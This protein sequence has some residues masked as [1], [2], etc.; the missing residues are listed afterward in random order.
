[1]STNTIGDVLG[2][3]PR[4]IGTVRSTTLRLNEPFIDTVRRFAGRPGT[5]ALVS[6]GTSDCAR[7]HILGIDPWLTLQGTAKTVSIASGGST[8]SLEEEPLAMFDRLVRHYGLAPLE[9]APPIA[10]GLLGYLSYDL[11]DCLETLPRTSVDD[12][13]LP[14]I[15]MVAP[16]I[17]LVSDRVEQKTTVYLPIVDRLADDTAGRLEALE[18]ALAR[19]APARADAAMRGG[20]FKSGF[21]RSEY[22][23]SV[24]AIREYIARGDVYQVNMSQRFQAR[25]EGDPF[26]LFAR[27]YLRNP[28][29]FF[30]YINAGNHQ[31]VSTS[32]ERFLLLN[33]DAVETRPIKGTRRRGGT[34]EED[35]L[36]S[37][38]REQSQGRVR[39][40]DDR[41]SSAQRYRQGMSRRLGA[42]E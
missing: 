5:V 19:P 28:A 3:L 24:D 32:P 22:M 36:A 27:L 39:A 6:G 31:I 16:S 2:T 13:R 33:D 34:P 11:K 7:Y 21:S 20:K 29:P 41:R 17:L 23:A 40:V 15:Y 18:L 30:A 9:G 1:M 35:A 14:H 38:A 12:L 4:R 42:R 10:A 37:R 8:M 26:E 25:F